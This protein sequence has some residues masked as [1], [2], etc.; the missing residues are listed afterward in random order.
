VR[1]PNP[2]MTMNQK[3]LS[4]IDADGNA[5]V[6][7]NRPEVHNA[8]DPEMV[9][10]LT[11]TLKKLESNDKVRAVVITGSGRSFCAGADIEHMKKTAKFSR[12]Q[13]L[14]NARATALMLRTLYTLE[15]PTLA[16]VRGAVRGGG[17][18]LVSACD[19]AIAERGATF[20]LSEV[21]LGIIPAMISPFVIGAIGRR[22]AHRYML[23]GEEF[24]AAEAFRI[25][26]V[27]D[28]CEEPELNALI[29][30]MLANL[31][32]SGPNALVA[33]KKLIP[34]VAAARIDES[35]METVSARIADIRTT[36]E[37]QEGLSSFLEKR[38]TAWSTPASEKGKKDSNRQD[39]KK[40]KNKN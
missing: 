25:G 11:S 19:I 40:S 18:G 8:F 1:L 22:H 23:S 28:I 37:A 10:A 30:R 21:K 17:V 14:E 32:S 7:L 12:A 31:Y 34:Q 13:N 26:L 35:L 29:G 3:V 9:D 39:A 15:K 16:C 36:A 6:M 2:G 33:I 24:D 4:Q 20:R 27:H 5:T 38:K